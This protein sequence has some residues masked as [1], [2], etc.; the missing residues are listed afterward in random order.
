[1]VAGAW[2]TLGWPRGHRGPGYL[3]GAEWGVGGLHQGLGSGTEQQEC[4]GASVQGRVGGHVL[5]HPLQPVGLGH[6]KDLQLRRQEHG[7]RGVPVTPHC[8]DKD[9]PHPTGTQRE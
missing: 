1:M 4:L 6:P 5:I 7:I 3:A 8:K 9:V 2:D